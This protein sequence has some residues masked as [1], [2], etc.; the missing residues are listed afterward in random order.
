MDLDCRQTVHLF[1]E[2]SQDEEQ[3]VQL[4]VGTGLQQVHD[5]RPLRLP[6]R[7]TWT[8]GA[9]VG[10]EAQ[11]VGLVIVHLIQGMSQEMLD[12][13]NLLLEGKREQCSVQ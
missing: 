3:S 9:G 5:V 12:S 7:E 2:V 11:Q 4:H 13:G 8:V 6:V 1:A 10:H